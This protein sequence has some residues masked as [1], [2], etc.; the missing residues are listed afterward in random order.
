MCFRRL[1]RFKN[2]S[3]YTI[4]V[5]DWIYV[6]FVQTVLLFSSY[7]QAGL[8]KST[9]YID[10]YHHIPSNQKHTPSWPSPTCSKA[11]SFQG[12]SAKPRSA[13]KL[14]DAVHGG[15]D[16][17]GSTGGKHLAPE[18]DL[19]DYQVSCWVSKP[20][21]W[22]ITKYPLGFESAFLKLCHV[23]ACQKKG[24]FHHPNGS[25]SIFIHS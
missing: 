17:V 4:V 1:F 7:L 5:L 6:C 2:S 15:V 20:R 16:G 12:R 11:A 19:E 3:K 18:K 25:K 13:G 24:T 8:Y 23:R 22:K 9:I 14:P 10:I 21:I